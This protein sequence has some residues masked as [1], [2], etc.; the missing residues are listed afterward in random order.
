MASCSDARNTLASSD[1]KPWLHVNYALGMVLGVDDLTQEFAYLANRDQWAVRELLG[2]GTVSG[3]AVQV[4]DTADGPRV[5]V[6]AGSAAVPS[7]KLVCVPSEQCALINQWLAKP[8]NTGLVEGLLIPEP[9]SSS[10][11][12]GDILSLYLTLCYA[13]CTTRPVPI[14]GD[15][16]RSEDQ[17]MA[18]SRVADDYCL[19]LRTTPPLQKEHDALLDFI[20]WLGQVPM[21]DTAPPA[22][23]DP[24]LEQEW[25]EAI[26]LAAKPWLDLAHASPPESPLASPPDLDD[27]L[28]GSP[29]AGLAVASAH[30]TAFL[31]VALRVWVTELRPLWMARTCAA[32]PHPE[33]DCLLLA[34]LAVPVIRVG[35][36]PAGAWQVDGTATLV[37]IDESSRP[38]LVNAR[39]LQA[40][41][42]AA[43]ELDGGA[44]ALP[45]PFAGSLPVG[46]G[47]TWVS[48]AL[49]GTPG[50]V[51]VND[52][53]SAIELVL[54]QPIAPAS[55]PG[56]AGLTVG[57]LEAG[58]LQVNGGPR[59]A[60]R[61]LDADATPAP[62]DY[63]LICVRAGITVTL[64]KCAEANRGKLYVVKNGNRRSES[65]FSGYVTIA[66]GRGDTLDGSSTLTLYSG[67]SYVFVSDGL[68]HWY[69]V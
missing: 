15:P 65:I 41:L 14:P 22:T 8:D 20:S 57:S 10:P 7:G 3:L 28:F 59:V 21:L 25:V 6:S 37:R 33:Q 9:P 11:P 56:F 69:R 32:D 52:G 63:C 60:I 12:G 44:T 19:E 1:P 66:V 5:R 68:D 55:T 58:D 23:L 24:E 47:S 53:P 34:R 46:D 45:P 13:D 30:R 4:D 48:K 16:C 31:R 18:D 43:D 49:T 36:S 67:S 27:Y 62:E 40:W 17:L 50:Q 2:Y 42:L 38:L 39:L 35:D 29:P 61:T 54:P 64:P 26:R 51:T